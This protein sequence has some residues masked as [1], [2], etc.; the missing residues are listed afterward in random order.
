M[1]AAIGFQLTADYVD[2]ADFFH[3][4][5]APSLGPNGN[6]SLPELTLTPALSLRERKW[7]ASSVSLKERALLPK[8]AGLGGLYLG[9]Q[10][11]FEA[12]LRRLRC[13]SSRSRSLKL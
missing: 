2:G 7:E 4:R 13:L 5:I 10:V 8:P 1:V 9:T 3:V 6:V 12:K 11:V